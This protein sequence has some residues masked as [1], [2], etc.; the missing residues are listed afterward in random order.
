LH[1]LRCNDPSNPGA[2]FSNLIQELLERAITFHVTGER[3]AGR[4]CQEGVIL[5]CRDGIDPCAYKEKEIFLT[6]LRTRNAA[7]DESHL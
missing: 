4:K 3:Q 1:T 6:S 7:R 2:G 5:R